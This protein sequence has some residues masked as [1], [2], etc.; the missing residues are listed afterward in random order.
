MPLLGKHVNFSTLYLP[1][2]MP[3]SDGSAQ[4]PVRTSLTV[5]WTEEIVIL[6]RA[7]LVVFLWDAYAC[8]HHT[9]IISIY[10][11]KGIIITSL[12]MAIHLSLLSHPSIV[13]ESK[14][15]RIINDERRERNLDLLRSCHRKETQNTSRFMS[16]ITFLTVPTFHRR[17]LRRHGWR[18]PVRPVSPRPDG[19][20]THLLLYERV[21]PQP[22]LPGRP[23]RQ[24]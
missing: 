20:R 1:M 9:V 4:L 5:W 14:H 21:R 10:V 17:S 11:K 13:V 3:S 23:V 19:G 2:P 7:S 22:L 8:F 24:Y 15:L 16:L 18:L 6:C 12:L